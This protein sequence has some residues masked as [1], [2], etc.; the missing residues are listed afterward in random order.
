MEVKKFKNLYSYFLIESKRKK[1]ELQLEF[2]NKS[3]YS[4]I[5]KTTTTNKKFLTYLKTNPVNL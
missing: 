1:L 4:L 2:K 5:D 3:C